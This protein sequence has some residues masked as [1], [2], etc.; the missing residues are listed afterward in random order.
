[1]PELPEVETVRRGLIP[2]LVGRKLKRVAVRRGDLRRPL[3]KDFAR[4]LSGRRVAAIDRR[5]KFLLV[6]LD[7]G[8]VLIVHLGMSGRLRVHDGKPPPLAAHDHVILVTD[9]DREVR[10][11]DP[12]RFGLMALARAD[13]L[14]RHPFLARLGPEPL[15]A[16]F[17]GRR[18]AARLEGRATSIKAAL[19]DQ[20]V[21]AGLGNIYVCE[22][23]FRAR[24]SPR[25]RAGTVAG[26][27]AGRL[28]RAI[29]AVLEEAIAAGGSSLRDHR[30]PSGELGYF[31]HR[32]AVYGREG[33]RCPGCTCDAKRA[34]GIRRIAQGGRST[35]YCPT[36]QR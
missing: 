15:D 24:L 14:A 1:M 23:L 11:N 6:R 29:K 10:F 22:S 32:F 20:R 9:R 5:G 18:L 25:R 2:V 36:Q 16:A 34:G 3:P 35:F 21:V 7:G 27:R 31:Q 4:R 28:A 8:D 17:D 19:M 13:E 12:R 33:G 30:Q 26:A